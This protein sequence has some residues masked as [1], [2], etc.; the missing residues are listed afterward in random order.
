MQLTDVAFSNASVVILLFP[1][2]KEPV[3]VHPE[4]FVVFVVVTVKEFTPEILLLP[5]AR[6][7]LI[8]PP[9]RFSLVANVLSSSLLV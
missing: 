2:F 9:E 4:R 1:I 8:V 3:I 6:F 7:P 5:N